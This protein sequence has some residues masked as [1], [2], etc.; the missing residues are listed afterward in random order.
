MYAAMRPV[1]LTKKNAEKKSYL[2]VITVDWTRGA[3]DDPLAG[4]LQ[5]FGNA[6]LV[7]N[8]IAYLLKKL[9]TRGKISCNDI[10]I[11]GFS[12]GASIAG[13]VGKR[14]KAQDCLIPRIT[15][16]VI[17]ICPA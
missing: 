10:H 9:D 3:S 17:M 1:L 6:R 5:S 8:Q 11:I 2:N 14:L 7:S 4:F 12:L 15:G 13:L 16:I